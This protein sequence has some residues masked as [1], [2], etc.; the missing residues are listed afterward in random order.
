VWY[1]IPIIFLSIGTGV[2]VFNLVDKKNKSQTIGIAQTP[3]DDADTNINPDIYELSD[4]ETDE[5]SEGS[6]V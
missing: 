5:N 6:V 4:N 1:W 2:L 3:A